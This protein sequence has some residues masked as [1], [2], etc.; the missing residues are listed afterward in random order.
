MEKK[1][2]LFH[3]LDKRHEKNQAIKDRNRE[4]RRDADESKTFLGT[5]PITTS[6]FWVPTD[7]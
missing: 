6:P 5:I 4:A 7:V 1:E 2:D 3:K